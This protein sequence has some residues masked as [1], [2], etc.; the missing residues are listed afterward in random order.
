MSCSGTAA[1]SQE[2]M[3]MGRRRRSAADVS[4]PKLMGAFLDF[5]AV[6]DSTNK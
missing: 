2:N 6:W 1:P 5:K 3:A 4:C